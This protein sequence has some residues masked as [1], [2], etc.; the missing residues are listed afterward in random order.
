[1]S[2]AERSRALL[3][4]HLFATLDKSQYEALDFGSYYGANLSALWDRL[5]TDVER[6]IE[7]VWK[8]SELSRMALGEIEFVKI[9]DLLLRVQS[10]D[11]SFGWPD[12]F[13]VT[14]Q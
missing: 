12:R 7:I 3:T 9:H 10:Q 5:S 6:P 2:F 8:E 1:V 11:E 14:F 4:S 13:S